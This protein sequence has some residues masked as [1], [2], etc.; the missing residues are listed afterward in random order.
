[1]DDIAAAAHVS[2]QTIYT[3]FADK[4]ALFTD[5]VLGNTERVNEFVQ[6][7]VETALAAPDSRA[8]LRHLARTYIR[9]V[10]RPEVL[11]LRRLVIGESG[12][13]PEVARAYYESVPQRMYDALSDLMSDLAARDELRIQDPALAA[14]QFAWLILGLPI[15]RGMFL[16]PEDVMTDDE[17]DRIADAAVSAFLAAYGA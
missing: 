17:L 13:F 7:M 14:H 11:R 12:R 9:T 15:D 2:K 6:S 8:A 10:S 1:M 16:G 4:E 5:L 3:H